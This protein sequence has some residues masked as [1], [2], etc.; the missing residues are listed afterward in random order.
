M[1]SP[2][3]ICGNPRFCTQ[4]NNADT[5]EN[6]GPTLSGTSS[7]LL[8]TVTKLLGLN[9]SGG[10]IRFMPLL[11]ESDFERELQVCLSGTHYEIT[12][13]KPQGFVRVKDGDYTLT[14]DGK[15]HESDVLPLFNDKKQHKVE[16]NFN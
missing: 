6:I 9:T 12:V 14:V 1:R 10:K 11:K 13:T 7:W 4:Y 2:F 16:M 5:G 8:L 15:P 3:T